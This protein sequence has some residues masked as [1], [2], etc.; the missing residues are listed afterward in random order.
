MSCIPTRS[1]IVVRRGSPAQRERQVCPSTFAMY[2]MRNG[3]NLGVVVR[4]QRSSSW[5]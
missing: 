2:K 4:R 5:V 3:Y 1:A